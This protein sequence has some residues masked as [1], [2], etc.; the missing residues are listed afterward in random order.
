MHACSRKILCLMVL[1]GDLPVVPTNPCSIGG[2][3]NASSYEDRN[4]GNLGQRYFLFRCAPR[5]FLRTAKLQQQVVQ[6]VLLPLF[7]IA[8]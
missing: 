4:L 1:T 3:V 8:C 7:I 5:K 2:V 6:V